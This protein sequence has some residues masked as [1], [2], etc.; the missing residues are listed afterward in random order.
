MNKN[1]KSNVVGSIITILVL[2]IMAVLG[3]NSDGLYSSQAQN[4]EQVDNLENVT[5]HTGD[6]VISKIPDDGNLRVYCLD[7]GQGDAILVVNNNR[8]ML[9]DASTNQMGSKVVDYLRKLGITKIDY[10]IGTHPHEDHIGGLDNV[11]SSFVIDKF[12][13]PKRQ[14]NTKTFED[15]LDAASKKK[16]KISTPSVG[17]KFNVGDAECEVMAIDNNAENLNNCSIVIQM[18]Y[19]GVKYLFTGDME[20]DAEASRSWNQVDILKVGHHGSKSSSSKKFL[21]QTKPKIAL[22]SCGEGNDYGH[23]HDAAVK[24]IQ[25]IGAKIYRTDKDQTI[26][27]LQEPKLR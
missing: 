16:L 13:M 26:M 20:S 27:V 21:D 18:S 2:I 11:I 14:A 9:I 24:R 4:V 6:G 3:A 17:E 10:L 12:Y 22:I 5:I 15:V 19:D 1:N 25:N 23:P 7:V 8:T